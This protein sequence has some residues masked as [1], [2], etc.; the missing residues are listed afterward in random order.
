MTK[1]MK[2]AKYIFNKKTLIAG[3]FI[4]TIPAL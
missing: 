4:A 3:T 1:N 2:I